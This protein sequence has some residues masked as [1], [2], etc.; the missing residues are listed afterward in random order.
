MKSA[1]HIDDEA[2]S[3]IIYRSA[4]G[5]FEEQIWNRHSGATP[6]MVYAR[7]DETP[8]LR[9]DC[10]AGQVSAKQPTIGDRILVDATLQSIID[11]KRQI[12]ESEWKNPEFQRIVVNSL[13]PKLG[14]HPSPLSIAQ[15]LAEC[16]F[17]SYRSLRPELI[18]VNESVMEQLRGERL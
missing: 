11:R 8:L 13:A 4:E 1:K 16:E 3:V 17:E 10:Q 7:D 5:K 14:D 9:V 18:V 15:H 12:V 2:L 6:F